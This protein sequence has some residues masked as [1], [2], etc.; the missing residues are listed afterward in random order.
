MSE[1]D[2]TTEARF[3][4]PLMPRANGAKD[5]SPGQRPGLAGIQAAL[6]GRRALDCLSEQCEPWR[7]CRAPLHSHSK[8]QRYPGLFP[9][10]LS[11][12]PLQVCAVQQQVIRIN[13]D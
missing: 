8:T 5:T 3:F 7:P 6:R 9:V 1:R 11:A 12:P 2:H 13:I 4:I 10:A